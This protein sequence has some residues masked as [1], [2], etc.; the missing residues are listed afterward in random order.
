MQ[1]EQAQFC[2]VGCKLLLVS[3]LLSLVVADWDADVDAVDEFVEEE[4]G[5]ADEGGA[6]VL[7]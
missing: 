6:G 3:V 4:T 2:R 5:R 7:F 1:R